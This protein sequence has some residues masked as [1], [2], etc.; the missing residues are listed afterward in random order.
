MRQDPRLPD[1]CM[2]PCRPARCKSRPADLPRECGDSSPPEPPGGMRSQ[3]ERDGQNRRDERRGMTSGQ[4]GTQIRRS[5]SYLTPISLIPL[6]LSIPFIPS[7]SSDRQPE[8]DSW[9]HQRCTRV[10]HRLGTAVSVFAGSLRAR[11]S[12]EPDGCHWG[13]A[14]IRVSAFP[15]I[16]QHRG[17][18]SPFVR[19]SRKA[20]H[21][22]R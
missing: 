11:G 18:T 16:H 4:Q 9:D 22:R 2:V 21:G 3:D 1:L 13:N 20:P 10:V 17:Q 8:D 15:A 12:G 14:E 6:I 19:F 5:S 7:R